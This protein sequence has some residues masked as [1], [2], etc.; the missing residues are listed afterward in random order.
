[1][2]EAIGALMA[3][4][5]LSDSGVREEIEQRFFA[6]RDVF[7][8]L[9]FFVFALTIDLDRTADVGWIVLLALAA[10]FVGKVGV[11]VVA[12]RLGGFS[13]AARDQRG[14]GARR[15]R[16]VHD[17]PRPARRRERRARSGAPRR[18]RRV[19]RSLRPREATVGVILMKE[20]K[21]LGRSWPAR[22][23]GRTRR[24]L[25]V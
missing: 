25:T 13:R 18:H 8:A 10:T 19:R 11:G 20:S 21:R 24:C 5:V 2:S 6:V 9:F 16:R 1:M 22:V 12:G 3:G 17:H 23:P 15:A 14:S 4:V 7:A